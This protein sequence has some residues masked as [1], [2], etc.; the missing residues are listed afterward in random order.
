[1]HSGGLAYTLALTSVACWIFFRLGLRRVR[2]R[3]GSSIVRRSRARDK[4]FTNP[5]D[6]CLKSIPPLPRHG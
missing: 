5:R 3:T 2:Q 6:S 1:M 4:M